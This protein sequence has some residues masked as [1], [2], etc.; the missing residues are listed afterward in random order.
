M[1]SVRL[2]ERLSWSNTCKNVPACFHPLLQELQEAKSPVQPMHNSFSLFFHFSLQFCCCFVCASVLTDGE[3]IGE[4]AD[5]RKWAYA[6][7]QP[8]G[9]AW[10]EHRV[11]G[12]QRRAESTAVSFYKRHFRVRAEKLKNFNCDSSQNLWCSQKCLLAAYSIID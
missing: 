2:I 9:A 4:G 12:P 11:W 3:W 6:A 5:G 7:S 8:A 10:E 1:N